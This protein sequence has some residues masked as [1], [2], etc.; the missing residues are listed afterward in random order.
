MVEIAWAE[1]YICPLCLKT[2][3]D[4]DVIEYK[5]PEEY[6]TFKCKHIMQ[7][8]KYKFKFERTH[9]TIETIDNYPYFLE[10]QPK[11]KRMKAIKNIRRF[12][13]KKRGW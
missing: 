8:Q 7:Q 13:D 5:I 11:S 9:S 12:L 10:L 6:I 1:G 3:E 2:C 4:A